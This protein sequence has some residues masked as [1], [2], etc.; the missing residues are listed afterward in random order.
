MAFVETQF[1]V[2]YSEQ[3]EVRLTTMTT[4][5]TTP[6]GA[7]QRIGQWSSGRRQYDVGYMTRTPAMLK[8]VTDFY[9]AVGGRL[10]G[11]RF[12]DWADYQ[13]AAEA[14]PQGTSTTL[15]LRK[16]YTTGGVTDYRKITKPVNNG[17]FVL[18]KNGVTLTTPAQ[19]TLDY[20]TGVVTLA[21]APLITDTITW[22]GEFDVPV[23]FDTD[24]LAFTQD[25]VTMHSARDIM[26][27]ELRS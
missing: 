5:V 26:L 15:Q 13:A 8:V 23:R 16:A 4:V 20:T 21:S 18:K 12:K 24:V 6:S 14:L 19:Y 25:A 11:F 3:A 22:T 17:S 10:R 2:D 9:L 1:P 7:E 27:M